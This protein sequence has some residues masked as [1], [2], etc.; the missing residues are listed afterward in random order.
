MLDLPR[1]AAVNALGLRPTQVLIVGDSGTDDVGGTPLGIRT[2]IL[3]RTTG[4][5][6]GLDL[7][8]RMLIQKPAPR[9]AF[10]FGNP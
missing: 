6:H 8:T 10:R 9:P 2:L 7:V 5:I 1:A 4:R 3:P